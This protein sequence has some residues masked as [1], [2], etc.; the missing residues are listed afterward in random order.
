MIA[1]EP[2]T[3]QNRCPVHHTQRKTQHVAATPA[4][5]ERSADGVWH[6]HG[7]A[8]ARAV[9]RGEQT[10]QSG[11]RAEMMDVLPISI[12]RPILFQEGQPHHEQR[13]QTAR[14]FTPKFTSE[15]YTA[16]MESQADQVIAGLRREGQADLSTL[17]M[18]LAVAVVAQVVG[19][20]NSRMPGMERR[21]NAFFKNDNRLEG[22]SPQAIAQSLRSQSQLFWFYLVDVQPAIGARRRTPGEDVISHLIGRGYNGMSIL[23]ECITYGA[24]GMVTTREYIAIAAWHMLEQPALRQR[25]L[26][27]GDDERRAILAEILRIEPVIGVIHR[28]AT[29]DITLEQDG[30]TITI[31]TGERIAVDV[32]SANADVRLVGAE[33][34]AICPGRELADPRA[35][36]AVM[37]FGDGHHRCP[38][39]YIALQETDIFLRKLLAIETLRIVS[40]PSV[41][42]T[43]L[44]EGYELRNFTLAV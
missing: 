34:E 39:A 3:E 37:S 20:T 25:F 30:Q 7:Y 31:K 16:L 36:A 15:H 17:S 44:A 4:P 38:G 21:L 26:V 2:Q 1:N 35:D 27:A 10:R 12:K 43:K 19:L 41:R 29:E 33:P 40:P 9:L 28:R 42:R 22:R 32:Y 18:Q 24:A 5:I 14:F 6:I 23:T 8:E 13:R 11:F